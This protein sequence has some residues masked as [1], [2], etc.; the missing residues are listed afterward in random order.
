MLKALENIRNYG[1]EQLATLFQSGGCC[2]KRILKI[3]GLIV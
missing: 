2:H 3:V 1:L